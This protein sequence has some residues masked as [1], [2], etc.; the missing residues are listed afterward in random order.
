MGA[1]LYRADDFQRAVPIASSHDDK[2]RYRSPW[3]RDYARLIH[4]AAFRRLQG[5]TQLFPSNESDF[6]RNRLTH[7]LEVAQVA[8]S[9]AIRINNT[10]PFFRSN[11]IDTDLIEL[12]ALA[13]DLG[14]P[15]FGH[16]GEMAL[17]ECMCDAGGFEGNAQTL[18]ILSKLEKRQ[19]KQY[20]DGEPIR[21][22]RG[23]DERAGLNLTYR[24][25]A[26]VLKYDS[27]IP[28]EEK[29]RPEHRK[30]VNKGYYY[31]EADLVRQ[32]KQRVGAVEGRQFKTIE[33]S[34][35]DA[36]DDIAYSTYDLE[37]AFKAH[38]LTPLSMLS[39]PDAMV[40]RVAATVAERLATHYPNLPVSER[41]FEIGDAYV[42]LF[43]IFS[44]MYLPHQE[45]FTAVAKKRMD[46]SVAAAVISAQIAALSE[47]TA[48]EGYY[49]TKLTSELVGSFV[50]AIRV[51]VDKKNPAL[52]QAYLDIA[53]FKRVEVLKNFAYQA[54]IMSPMLKVAEHRGKDIV[55]RIFEAINGPHGDLLMPDDFRVLYAQL[56]EPDERRR[57]ICDFIAGMTDRYAIQFYSRLFGTS[58]ESIYSPL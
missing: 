8:K 36:A 28:R 31:T 23:K 58:P 6:F 30:G 16:N 49:R 43:E 9:I 1:K 19:T 37:D 32:I 45:E 35:M 33:C 15:P 55:K 47:K 48:S 2:E 57:V 4:S 29:D 42:T 56:T 14:H 7:S 53:T 50:R 13:H 22:D 3:R 10:V 17:D 25:L 12:A 46:A 26:A 41:A 39:A 34:I 27:E 44:E 21:V 54:L 18:R 51:R 52:S 24:S 11:P 38:F 5:K 40:E 20:R